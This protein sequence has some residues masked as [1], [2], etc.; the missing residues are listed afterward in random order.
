MK[1]Q[2]ELLHDEFNNDTTTAEGVGFIR[3]M[4]GGNSAHRAGA[5]KA[6]LREGLLSGTFLR[7]PDGAGGSHCSPG[8]SGKKKKKPRVSNQP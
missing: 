3:D 6:G 7:S 1:M 8:P 4:L 5:L 2:C